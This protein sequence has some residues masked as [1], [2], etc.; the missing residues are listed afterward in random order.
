MLPASMGLPSI[1]IGLRYFSVTRHPGSPV[2][3][4][5]LTL[6]TN[7]PSKKYTDSQL[8]SRASALCTS[9]F[10]LLFSEVETGIYLIQASGG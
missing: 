10:F 8:A 6:G 9:F 4:M 7:L 5:A 1:Y 2:D 3:L